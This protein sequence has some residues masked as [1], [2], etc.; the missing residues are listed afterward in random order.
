MGAD[1]QSLASPE[2]PLQSWGCRG[3]ALWM[4]DVGRG[5]QPS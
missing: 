4:R 2:P 5:E 1:L 3:Q